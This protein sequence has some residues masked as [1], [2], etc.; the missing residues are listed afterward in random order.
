M[1]NTTQIKQLMKTLVPKKAVLL[2]IL[3][4]FGST[5]SNISAQESVPLT[6][7]PG[8]QFSNIRGNMVMTGNDIVGVIE[9]DDGNT[10]TNPNRSYNGNDNNGN[11]VH[12]V[13]VRRV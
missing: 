9:D 2:I 6:P 10:F 13:L 7:R 8:A 4:V 5:I 11:Y 3:I 12:L 1:N